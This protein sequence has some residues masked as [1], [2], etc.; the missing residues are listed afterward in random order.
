[1][2]VILAG[3]SLSPICRFVLRITCCHTPV[4]PSLFF[5]ISTTGTSYWRWSGISI[6]ATRESRGRSTTSSRSSLLSTPGLVL[7]LSPSRSRHQV[8]PV[9]GTSGST[10]LTTTPTI[11]ERISSGPLSRL[12]RHGFWVQ[13]ILFLGKNTT[14]YLLREFSWPSNLV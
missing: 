3:N 7:N 11:P 13:K 12:L 6:Q 1:M 5:M 8:S 14:N 2:S 4:T 9:L 10:D